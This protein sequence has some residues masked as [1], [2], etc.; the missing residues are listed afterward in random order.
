[1]DLDKIQAQLKSHIREHQVNKEE[2]WNV[3]V[4]YTE[5]ICVYIGYM[6]CIYGQIFAYMDIWSEHLAYKILKYLLNKLKGICFMLV[7]AYVFK[8][9]KFLRPN[10]L[11]RENMIRY[12]VF[13]GLLLRGVDRMVQHA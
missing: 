12:S 10:V 7:F 13:S 8:F 6:P 5:D 3:R 2:I 11:H 1:M 9:R 4:L